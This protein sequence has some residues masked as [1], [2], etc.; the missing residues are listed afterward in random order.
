MIGLTFLKIT[1][2]TVKEK[3]LETDK[4]GARIQDGWHISFL[5]LLFKKGTQTQWFKQQEGISS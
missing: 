1:L 5:G 4:G 2:P 3:R